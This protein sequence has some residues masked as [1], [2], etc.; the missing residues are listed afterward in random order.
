M[1]LVNVNP[2]WSV[3]AYVL[4]ILGLALVI[5]K[6]TRS[7]GA[8]ILGFILFVGVL[9][10]FSENLGLLHGLPITIGLLSSLVFNPLVDIV[11]TAFGSFGLVDF[12]NNIENVKYVTLGAVGVFWILSIILGASGKPKIHGDEVIKEGS[13]VAR[14]FGAIITLVLV[15]GIGFLTYTGYAYT[16]KDS[17]EII[18]D[19][20]SLVGS[21]STSTTL[22]ASDSSSDSSDSSSDS[23]D[24]SAEDSSSEDSSESFVFDGIQ[25]IR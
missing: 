25:V 10:L 8:S 19:N 3:V 16:E 22:D 20:S 2:S 18:V 21:D 13:K 4:L 24:S 14:V 9:S 12:A 15:A 11:K 6:A 23:S 5:G 1:F 7:I 17:S